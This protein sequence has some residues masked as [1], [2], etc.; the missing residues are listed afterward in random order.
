[1]NMSL[2]PPLKISI[3]AKIVR[4]ITG[5]LIKRIDAKTAKV[6][7]LRRRWHGF[8]VI[9]RTVFGVKA[10]R[11]A[12]QGLP[13]LWMQPRR[14]TDNKL[15]LYLHG[16]AY[17]MGNIATHRQFVSFIAREAGVRALLPE[18]RLAPEHRFPAAVEDAAGLYRALLADGYAAEDI[19]VAGDSAGGGLTMAM[20]LALRDAD[21]PLPA[22]AC[23]LSPWLDLAAAGETMTTRAER[24]PWFKPQDM[25]I[26]ADYY[27]EPGQRMNPLV[28]PVYADL[29]GLPPL[30]IQVGEEEILLS[31]STRAADKVTAAGGE[32]ELEIWPGMWHV[33][34][35]F[36]Y[37][38]P[39]A[40]IATRK[41]GAY[42]RQ[43]LRVASP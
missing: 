23:L 13:A 19:V 15:L 20:L 43:V 25:P 35:M 3:R 33:F 41:I 7:S 30:Y 8:S 36:V 37:L 1:M 4:W 38:M 42:I 11:S 40:K 26:V 22:A 24:D 5:A 28:S 32:V 9:L 34:Q 39:E 14:A 18:Y 2:Q 16:G 10:N 17:I 21:D 29:S 6:A 12:V 27:C 31:D